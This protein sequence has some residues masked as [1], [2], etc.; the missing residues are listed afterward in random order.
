MVE[1]Y[2]ASAMTFIAFG[3]DFQCLA[4]MNQIAEHLV[5]QV[6]EIAVSDGGL[7]V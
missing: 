7:R 6:A 3:V 2:Y 4:F 5:E 1:L